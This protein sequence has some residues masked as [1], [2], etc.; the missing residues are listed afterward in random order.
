MQSYARTTTPT[1]ARPE[2]R[3]SI[4]SKA[5]F[6][7]IEVQRIQ[8]QL[9]RES[10]LER[11]ERQRELAREQRELA[12]A[13]R[14]LRIRDEEESQP[15]TARTPARTPTRRSFRDSKPQPIVCS[16]AVGYM[17]DE[18]DYEEV[19]YR[20]AIANSRITNRR[21]QEQVRND[22]AI[23]RALSDEQS[24]KPP[25]NSLK[26]LSVQDRPARPAPPTNDA[27]IA[28]E[29]DEQLN[30]RPAARI[31]TRRSECPPSPIPAKSPA[32][33]KTPARVSAPAPERTQ[34]LPVNAWNRITG[35]V[36][37]V[38]GNGDCGANAISMAYQHRYDIANRDELR[39]GARLIRSIAIQFYRNRRNHE[40]YFRIRH[41][42]Q[43]TN[44]L[45]DTVEEYCDFMGADGVH[46]TGV[47]FNALAAVLNLQIVVAQVE[48]GSDVGIVTD[49]YG[50]R[51]SEQVFIWN[52]PEFG[53]ADS[54]TFQAG[55][56]D[57]LMEPRILSWEE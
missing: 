34:F 8:R 50:R 12:R 48:A 43:L 56:Y 13:T 27:T 46:F 10:A 35:R 42:S 55:H 24:K 32:L 17:S 29:L 7:S 39:G 41:H 47:E 15:T 11:R 44:A 3:R 52:T 37:K 30:G 14:A 40:E 18:D 1:R 31:P 6:Q 28:R 57:L 9:E 51:G 33:P 19:S 5:P 23:A 45:P 22:A 4:L 54:E 2:Q 49:I 16:P 38:L 36:V 53:S 26:R 20:Q 21:E 25:T